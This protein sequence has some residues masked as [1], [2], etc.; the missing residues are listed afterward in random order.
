[1]KRILFVTSLLYI[2]FCSFAQNG[3]VISDPN[4]EKRTA[5]SYHAVS[6][7][8]GIDLYLSQGDEAVAI[9]AS[10]AETRSHI[11]TEVVDGVLKIYFEQP[12]GFHWSWGNRK[13]KAYVS[14][15]TLD[16]L[17]ASGGS[18]VFTD[19]TLHVDKLEIS[20][21]GGSDFKGKVEAHELAL[22][23][24]GGSDIDIAGTVG[25]LRVDASGGSDLH[26][27]E[28]TTEVCDISA[29]GGSDMKIT[30][31]KELSVSAS[32]GSDVYYKGS[33]VVKNLHSSGSSS[34]SKK[35]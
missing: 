31:N 2:A 12:N 27:Y 4:A 25:S 11:R 5:S 20:L 24:S 29:S 3:K 13:M 15:K 33:G 14:F 23:Q 18:D 28:L 10:D 30:V 7:S 8:G 34:V 1:M 32:G 35:D 6:V 9:S 26:G 17:H 22:R 19:G 16:R 21:S